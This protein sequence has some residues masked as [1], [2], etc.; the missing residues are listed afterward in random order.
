M[1][2]LLLLLTL[3]SLLFSMDFDAEFAKAEADMK[4]MESEFETSKLAQINEFESYSK[5]LENEYTA[6]ENELSEYWK[7]PELSSKREW[8]SYSKDNKSRSK[9]DFEKNLISIEVIA[10]SKEQAQEQIRKRLEYVVS[11]NTK[12]VVQSD[13]LQKRVASIRSKDIT[14]PVIMD[15]KPILQSVIFDKKPSKK[16]IKKYTKKALQ[17]NKISIKKSKLQ[18]KYVYKMTVALPKNSMLKRSKV[19][20]DD[21]VKNAKD[22]IFQ[23][24]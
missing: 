4:A 18:D 16:D 7:S 21:I 19:Y 17:Q 23:S 2:K 9:V 1:K 5:S 8:V 14:K 22:L 6:Y 13:P 12:E 10:D 20:K 15:A 24:L 3:S 11:K